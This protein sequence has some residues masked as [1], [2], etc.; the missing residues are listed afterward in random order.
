MITLKELFL[1]NRKFFRF[2]VLTL[3]SL[4]SFGAN[5]CYDMPAVLQYTLQE[6]WSNCTN[7]GQHHK[8]CEECLSLGADRYNQLYTSFSWSNACIVIFSGFLTDRFGHSMCSLLFSSS[9]VAGAGLF[10]LS[11]ISNLRRAVAMYPLM[12][13]GR[14]LL[15]IGSGSLRIVQDRIVAFWFQKNELA[16][17]YGIIMAIA[18]LGSVMN[19]LMTKNLEYHFG[20]TKT[21][22]FGFSL[23]LFSLGLACLLAMIEY[24][25][26]DDDD[27]GTTQN[28]QHKVAS[29]RDLKQLS[30]LYWLINISRLF[31]FNAVVQF[32][33][34]ST[35][36]F[37]DKYKISPERSAYIIGA[38]Y[39]VGM[40]CSPF[41][42]FLADYTKSVKRMLFIGILSLLPV[43]LVLAYTGLNTIICTVWIG[44]SLTVCVICYWPVM[45]KVIPPHLLGS[46]LGICTSLTA[47]GVGTTS[48]VV[49]KILE[50]D[51]SV[52]LP[53]MLHLWRITMIY[54][55]MNV[56]MSFFFICLFFLKDKNRVEPEFVHARLRPRAKSCID[57]FDR[58]LNRNGS[59]N[60]FGDLKRPVRSVS[61]V[62][63]I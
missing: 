34:D 14:M 37:Q 12:L 46:G 24:S 26:K 29:L 30:C 47:I 61:C 50:H 57:R 32:V 53:E 56:F 20:L 9:I 7:P 54:L 45:T 44:L 16:T 52:T 43:F 51:E 2:V 36:F 55:T 21:L 62:G 5:Y 48:F 35:E 17:A 3:T 42:G 15:G 10:T 27:D 18:R 6:N 19:F 25:V 38:I 63:Y 1:Q 39:D 33:V 31:F 11:V 23:C 13:V 4:L 59:Y 60:T 22:F 58:R 40:I 41:V 8:C 28:K 49:G